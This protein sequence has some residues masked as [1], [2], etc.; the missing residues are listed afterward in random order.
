M[1]ERCGTDLQTVISLASPSR[2]R[3]D[4]FYR[5]HGV[6]HTIERDLTV[7]CGAAWLRRNGI[8]TRASRR[9]RA[10][11]NHMPGG[12]V[13]SSH[14]SVQFCTILIAAFVAV[15]ITGLSNAE[16]ILIED[17]PYVVQRGHLD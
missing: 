14:R 11:E 5:A 13:M 8:N 10:A 15:T 16:K 7:R 1:L 6:G 12:V 3:F 4:E 17:V 9:I 2:W